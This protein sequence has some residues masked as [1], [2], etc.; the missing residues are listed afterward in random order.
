MTFRLG[1]E[2]PNPVAAS[3]SEFRLSRKTNQKKPNLRLDILIFIQL[4]KKIDR[5]KD[6]FL[7]LLTGQFS[8][9]LD[10]KIRRQGMFLGAC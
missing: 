3:F 5:L 6:V 2:S 4:M 1:W 8:L 10:D 7:S 9:A